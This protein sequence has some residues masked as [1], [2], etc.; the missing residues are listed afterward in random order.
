MS[1]V[2]KINKNLKECLQFCQDYSKEYFNTENCAFIGENDKK[3]YVVKIAD[4]RSPQPMDFFMVDPL[5]YLEF[6][7]QNK[8]LFI[9]HSH[10]HTSAE[11]SQKDKDC[12]EAVCI[13]FLIYSLQ[14]DKFSLYVPENHEVDVNILNKVKGLI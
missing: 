1:Q 5:D 4:N 2:I 8:V 9:F 3:K 14:E 7:S 12:C 13:P 10:P 11:F 6:S